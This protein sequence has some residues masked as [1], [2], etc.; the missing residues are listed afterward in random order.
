MK[1]NEAL[2]LGLETSCDETAVALLDGA[3]AARAS[4]V[5][6]QEEAH[7]LF[8]G[9]VPEIAARAHLQNLPPLLDSVLDDAGASLTDVTAVAAT[10]GPGLVGALLVGLSEGKGLALGLSVPFV[11]VNHIEGHALS[12]FLDSERGPSAPVP[13]TF[14]ALV[15]SGGHT[16]LFS[17]ERDRIERLA[18]TRDD[19]AGE[20]FDKVAKMA[21]L[22]YP[23]GPAVDRLARRGH[24]VRP[25]PVPHFKDGSPDFSFSGLKTAARE[26]LLE[27]G[28]VPASGFAAGPSLHEEDAPQG[29]RDL[30]A[31]V[32]EAIV[33]QLLHRLSRLHD[34]RRFTIL[35]ISG[36]VAAN[37]L[38]RE[39]ISAWGRSRGVDVRLATRALTGDNAVMIAFAGLL[40]LR[41]GRTGE[42]L[43]AVARSRWPLE[44]VR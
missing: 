31:D 7:R 11:P 43:G 10:A 20:A 26:R 21:G 33:A 22:G 13:E 17:F 1:P 29:L 4:R 5:S 19:A 2:V 12:P 44:T 42:G 32:E 15:V 23:G 37:T 41:S 14:A 38:V 25:F 40:R 28:R 3:G 30:M 27:L 8:G 16:H 35:T 36:G 9:V 18:R 39:R 24:A 34:A 6:S